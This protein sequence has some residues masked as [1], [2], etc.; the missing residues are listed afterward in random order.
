[1]SGCLLVALTFLLSMAS[2][3]QT[4]TPTPDYHP[5]VEVQHED[6]G[7][8]RSHFKTNI[9]RKGPPPT[10]WE[11]L[12]APA[13]A[14]QIEYLS[15][16]LH[17]KAWITEPSVIGKGRHPAVLFLHSG[18]D[19]GADQWAA[20]QPFRDAGY[21]VMV[22][23]LRGENGQHG[24]FTMYY[25]EVNDVISA[26]EYLRAQ[27]YIDPDHLYVA[28]QSVGGTLAMLAAEMYRHFRA[29]ASI[30]GST[31]QAAYIKYARLAKENAPFDLTDPK[32]IQLRSP[33]AYA[34]SFKC[35]VR[36]YYGTDE[37]YYAFAAPRTAEIAS[38]HGVDAQAIAVKGGH[39]SDY[40]QSVKLAI[41]FFQHHQ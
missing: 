14:A 7:E 33:L 3:A 1:M 30:S 40:A 13:G 37:T 29:A 36:I 21:V 25:D 41:N 39:E 20:V 18:F 34:A 23:S 8:A 31:D 32:E 11:D 22:P 28:G 24:V 17:L 9:L 2:S 35:P 26:A 6:L 27:P 4:S 16:T 5:L 15:E 19:L 38:E 10:E 12:I